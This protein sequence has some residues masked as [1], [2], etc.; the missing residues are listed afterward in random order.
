MF[1]FVIVLILAFWFSRA[2]ARRRVA[3]RAAEAKAIWRRI[4][5]QLSARLP[6]AFGC[7]R[8]DTP[9]IDDAFV[10]LY[11]AKRMMQREAA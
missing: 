3:R 2:W 5:W 9:D 4:H 6:S 1:D 8:I 10:I 11:E 7:S